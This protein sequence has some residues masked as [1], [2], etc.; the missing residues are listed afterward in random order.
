MASEDYY[1]ALKSGKTA[2]RNA[3]IKGEYPY[4]PALDE[5]TQQ[6]DLLTGENLGLVSIPLNLIVGTK[7]AGRQNS[8]A[9]NFM[10]LM[11]ESSEFAR[12]WAHVYD[13]HMNQGI[14]DPIIAYEFMNRFYVLEG[15]KRVS[16]LKY[17]GADSIEG[18]VTRI[19]P[20]RSDTIEN[21][22]YYEFL[23]FYK[24]SEINYIW[25]SKVG[26]FP[27]LTELVGKKPGEKWTDDDRMNFRSAY[28]QFSEIYDEAGSGKDGT[29][30][31]D[32]FL[33]YLSLYPYAE[34]VSK[35]RAEMKDDFS[36]IAKEFIAIDTSPESALVMDPDDSEKEQGT[37]SGVGNAFAKFFRLTSSK[38]LKVAFI[39][40]K[41]TSESA[42]TYSHE[43]GRMA[44]EQ[45]F[46]G[47]VETSA[48]F[49]REEESDISEILENTIAGGSH[50][51][52][53]THQK[54]LAASLK[55]AIEHPKVRILN[56]SVNQP[57]KS[58]R[59]YYG[60]LYEAKFLGGMIAGAMC[61][62]GKIAYVGKYP[63]YGSMANIN[64]F[65]IGA[66]MTNP[67][68]KVYLYW[69]TQKDTDFEELLRKEQI[70]LV[71]DNDFIRPSS[72]GRLYGL[73]LRKDGNIMNLAAPIWN[74]GHFYERII[75]DLLQGSWD[76]SPD[77]AGKD[78]VN[79]Y[80]G[81]SSGILDLIMSQN[82][83]SGIRDLTRIMKQQITD[84][85][86]YPFFGEMTIQGGLTVGKKGKILPPEKIITMDYLMNNVV[87]S[88]PTQEELTDEANELIAMQTSGVT[89]D[90]MT[91]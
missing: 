76:S 31:G 17:V 67:R 90:A 13:Y 29:T 72:E 79:Y 46:A 23:A 20:Q 77:V 10:P 28:N 56:C 11:P 39:H 78:A 33:L 27:K 62:N 65:A 57:Y 35:S 68:A 81:M 8:F 42:W 16:V 2:Y 87:G 44:L 59:T 15:N 36:K 63:I 70:S 6:E 58:L 12:K 1:K 32:A 64:A 66:Q 83:P 19:I 21:K 38:T 5:I 54:F 84:D 85:C 52:F 80:W 69:D 30:H 82:L 43:L 48:Y 61:E 91:I 86:F 74:W 4:L 50:V 55:A 24:D 71:S 45:I 75:R 22:I 37:F 40:D 41:P 73:Y 88:I 49:Y 26:S 34:V 51:I 9:V 14:G 89:P 3:V 25:F 7:T 53:T 18:T 60:R 47:K